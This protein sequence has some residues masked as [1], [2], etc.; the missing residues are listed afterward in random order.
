MRNHT[1]IDEFHRQSRWNRRMKVLR[2]TGL[3]RARG[4]DVTA[5]GGVA[6]A[7]TRSPARV[8]RFPTGPTTWCG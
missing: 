5:W 1:W 6:S 4:G 7:Q 3:F 2:K 8:G